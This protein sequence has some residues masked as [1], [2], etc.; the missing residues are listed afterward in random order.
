MHHAVPSEP[1]SFNVS[2]ISDSP[3]SLSISWLPP[4]NQNGIIIGYTVYCME[5]REQDET[6]TSSIGMESGDSASDLDVITSDN[7][8]LTIIV[9]PSNE[10]EI[11]FPDL[12]PYTLYSC[13]ASA[14][15]SAGEGNFTVQLKART[16]DKSGI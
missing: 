2:M 1:L 6:T 4:E 10:T 11:T 9:V 14:N 13:Y 12:T 8:I 15:T 16:D 3:R 7:S 5:E